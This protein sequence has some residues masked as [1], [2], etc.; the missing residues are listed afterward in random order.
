MKRS[1]ILFL[2]QPLFAIEL[3]EI[4]DFN[5]H[6]QP[7]LSEYCYHCHGPDSSTR[8]PEKNPLRF[9]R[10][11]FAFLDRSNGKPAIIKGNSTASNLIKRII[12][13]E[14]PMPPQDGTS[15]KPMLQPEQVALLKKWIDQGAEYKEHW[16][17]I[18]PEKPE[19][20]KIKWG[21]NLVDSFIGQKHQQLGI[22]AN[23]PAEPHRIVRRLTFDLTGLPPTPEE[24]REFEDLAAQGIE[25]AVNLTTEKLLQTDSFAEHFARHWLDTVRYGDTHG[26]HI[27]NYR[28]IWPYR[29]WVIDSF[30]KNQSFK[31]FTI[32]QLAGD[33]M[34][35]ATLEQKIATGYCRCMPTTGEGGAIGDEYRAIY[36]KDQVE[37]TS[38][39]WLGL[40]TGCAACHDH[41]F[42]PISQSDFYAMTAF[43]RN[44]TMNPMDRNDANHPPNVF[45]PLAKDRKRWQ[46]IGGDILAVKN[47][48]KKRK[49]SPEIKAAF[50]AWAIAQGTNPLD[51]AGSL[52]DIHLPLVIKKNK[53]A[54]TA[55]GAEKTW[56]YPQGR[57]T[58]Q[59]QKVG[60][61]PHLNKNAIELGDIAKFG[62]RDKVT[63][64]GFI[65]LDGKANGP[66]ISRMHK[67]KSYRGWDL[68]L[69]NDKIG[70]HIIDTWPV[71]AIKAIT[72]TPLKQKTWQHVMVTYDGTAAPDQSLQ[73]FING[74]LQPLNYSHKTKVANIDGAVPLRLAN[75]HGGMQF[76][77]NASF[78]DFKLFRRQ[79]SAQEIKASG[80]GGNVNA[81][82]T[83]PLAER[84]PD[85]NKA[86]LGFYS[87]ALDPEVLALQRK[88]QS[89]EAERGRLRAA[90]SNTLVMQ[91]KKEKAYAHILERGEYSIKGDQVFANIPELFRNGSEKAEG[92]N[93]LDLANWLVS[94][95]NPLTARVTVNRLWY[96]FLGRGLVETTEDFG[97]MGARPTHPKLLDWLAIEFMESGWDIRHVIKLITSSATY[98]LS[99]KVESA[100]REKDPENLYL[101][102]S[103]R[104]RLEAEQIRDHALASSGL[105]VRKVGG[106]SVKPYQP[107]G[108]WEAV[109]MNQSNTRFYKKDKGENLYRRSVYTFW[110][111]T[112]A[113][114]SMEILNAPTREFFCVRRDR[115]NTPLQAFVTMNDVQFLEAARHLATTAVRSGDTFDQRLDLISRKLLGRIFDNEERNIIRKSLDALTARYQ[116]DEELAE[117]LLSNGDTPVDPSIATPE[118]A[119]WMM[120]TSQVF[121]LDENLTK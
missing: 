66:I 36:A 81:L 51:Q 92:Q 100:Q 14:D 46:T 79:L 5:D 13:V 120:V 30:R 18:K 37:T 88:V 82:L 76:T 33:L 3:P 113:P 90:G 121:N 117:K 73:I 11:E 95:D 105:L 42:D 53:L 103:S 40:T 119:S 4:V 32:D 67:N 85:Q 70:T 9:D 8:E 7:L 72:K 31:D 28:A 34:P 62:A 57:K 69:E 80:S 61:V 94:E 109:A 96:Y 56:N 101:G 74:E 55:D 6:V 1:L 35:G 112:A 83:I 65:Y 54:G 49:A 108:L 104:F 44:T 106:P 89:L 39:I 78:Y 45:A 25:T 64:G 58:T 27:D 15:H 68:W 116:R 41:K 17:F 52:T 47:Q 43:F 75:R 115:T 24:V 84:T 21:N 60:L 16:S 86:I 114:A 2:A 107:D 102:R 20:P 87:K 98:Q 111:R 110:K 10:E 91:E 22:S 23:S 38:A 29:D 77:G 63:F 99:D 71:K 19:A 97:I 118:L 59:V 26:V 50:E 48:L 93:R 12:D